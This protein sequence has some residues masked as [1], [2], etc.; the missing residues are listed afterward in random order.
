MKVNVDGESFEIP[1]EDVRDYVEAL[2]AE[3]DGEAPGNKFIFGVHVHHSGELA[4]IGEDIKNFAD[5]IGGG[6]I[7]VQVSINAKLAEFKDK[8]M[9]FTAHLEDAIGD[10]QPTEYDD[11]EDEEEYD[12]D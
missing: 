8:V 7:E 11:Y 4:K 6:T 10:V 2:D 1:D 5:T 9:G 12:E 3:E